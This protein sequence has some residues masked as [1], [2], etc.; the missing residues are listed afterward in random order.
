M[1]VPKP[2]AA[3]DQR[4]QHRQQADGGGIETKFRADRIEQRRHHGDCGAQA[5]RHDQDAQQGPDTAAPGLAQ[6]VISHQLTLANAEAR[7]RQRRT[8]GFFQG[9]CAD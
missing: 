6:E 2:P 7:L 9:R 8:I 5:Q 1:G 3:K 4:R